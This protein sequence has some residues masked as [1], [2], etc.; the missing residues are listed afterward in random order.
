MSTLLA[1]LQQ[2]VST[3]SGTTVRARAIAPYVDLGAGPYRYALARWS[4]RR[5]PIADVALLWSPAAYWSAG[6]GLRA[7][8]EAQ[9]ARASAV[10]ND[11]LILLAPA[12]LARARASRLRSWERHARRELED[13][14]TRWAEDH[15]VRRARPDHGFRVR[16]ADAAAAPL[17][18]QLEPGE[19]ATGVWA[20]QDFGARA[21]ASPLVELFQRERGGFRSALTLFSDRAAV[22]IGDHA[23]DDV[24]LPALGGPAVYRLLVDGDGTFV[25]V[26]DP[27]RADALRIEEGRHEDLKTVRLVDQRRR[28]CL[29]EFLLVA[30]REAA[31]EFGVAESARGRAPDLPGFEPG[32][33][34]ATFI[35][36]GGVSALGLHTVVPETRA[37]GALEL[38]ER[39]VL[40]RGAR[41]GGGVL[42]FTLDID[43]EG[44]VGPRV[45]DPVA[46]IEW[47]DRQVRLVD[48]AGDLSIDGVPHRA[49]SSPVLGGRRHV[50][51]W[52]GGGCE[53]DG[54]TPGLDA[55]LPDVRWPFVLRISTPRRRH[56]LAQEGPTRIGRDRSC[57]AIALPD[58]P[59]NENLLVGPGARTD[60]VRTDT[61]AVPGRAAEVELRGSQWIVRNISER[62]WPWIVRAGLA[63]R[64]EA[65]G[66]AELRRGDELV[67]GN[68]VFRLL[69]EGV[70]DVADA[71]DLGEEEPQT[72]ID[73]PEPPPKSNRREIGPGT[74]G[75][76]ARPG[77]ASGELVE[78]H[79]T[80][81]WQIRHLPLADSVMTQAR[82]GE[83]STG[84]S[85]V[86]ATPGMGTDGCGLG[87]AVPTADTRGVDPLVDTKSTV[88]WLPSLSLDKDDPLPLVATQST[89]AKTETAPPESPTAPAPNVRLGGTAR[90]VPRGLRWDPPQ[91]RW[92]ARRSAPL[93]GFAPPPAGRSGPISQG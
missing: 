69:E 6:E 49:G 86:G 2:A 68:Q 13:L 53:L 50:L 58:R 5:D 26:L 15:G 29:A 75:R 21:G 9:A 32:P 27:E 89:G 41:I 85:A 4:A 35:P 54:R 62:C 28:L 7:H 51:H 38:V 81:S 24:R 39:A 45:A 82:V 83:S 67:I 80:G 57:C 77:G 44:R 70:E 12:D 34:G 84:A 87:G 72:I 19:F 3:L 93:P 40:L 52:R 8:L 22:H 88:E 66:E 46:R 92:A 11:L 55:E 33:A 36:E 73:D 37:S 18:L 43:R 91:P 23:L 10:P 30:K 47:R 20:N 42:G 61:L 14:A 48:G 16:F 1:K 64:V 76:R 71:L 63:V 90:T 65:G 78:E 74:R 59:T 56:A 60:G 31:K 25:Q 17:P 79:L